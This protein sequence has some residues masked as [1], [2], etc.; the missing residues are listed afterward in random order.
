[1]KNIAY[2]VLWNKC[3]KCHGGN[4]FKYN[5]PYDLS[6]F[7]EMNEK[8]S[9]C[10]EQFE[11]EPGYF[12]GAMYVSYALMSGWFMITWAIDSFLVHSETWQYLTFFIPT[13]LLFMPLTFRISRLIWL[14]FF[15]R[16]DP[17]KANFAKHIQQ[18][19]IS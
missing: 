17:E 8:C 18:S 12:Y 7:S 15:V 6:H 11:K 9:C 16:F 13:I 2:S 4:V 5:N 14:N 1:M 10:S 3:P 19:N